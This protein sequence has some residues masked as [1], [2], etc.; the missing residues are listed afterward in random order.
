MA[1]CL[2]LAHPFDVPRKN[3][4]VMLSD[5][6]FLTAHRHN[7]AL[8]SYRETRD[9][10]PHWRLLVVAGPFGHTEHA[11]RFATALVQHRGH[12]LDGWRTHATRLARDFGVPAYADA[13]APSSLVALVD[14]LEHTYA[15]PPAYVQTAKAWLAKADAWT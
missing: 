7:S 3:V 10:A 5:R 12:G 2:A 11:L 13:A 14:A 4:V 6:P 15:A 1:Y 8:A 9:A